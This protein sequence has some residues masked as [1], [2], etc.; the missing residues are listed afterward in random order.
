MGKLIKE[1]LATEDNDPMGLL[2]SYGVFTPKKIFI[3]GNG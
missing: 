3:Q 1:I 2:G